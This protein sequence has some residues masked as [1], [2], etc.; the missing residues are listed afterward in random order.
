[1]RDRKGPS[2]FTNKV[3]FPNLKWEYTC[4]FNLMKRG[5]GA[6]I[7]GLSE[8]TIGAVESVSLNQAA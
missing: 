3:H 1:M 8:R 7:L 5:K 4:S 2:H 6:V